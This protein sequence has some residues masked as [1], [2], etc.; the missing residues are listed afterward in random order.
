MD[1]KDCCSK[2]FLTLISTITLGCICAVSIFMIIWIK[3]NQIDQLADSNTITIVVIILACASLLLLIFSVYASCAK[4]RCTSF[5]LAVILLVFDVAL[6]AGA[7]FILAYKDTFYG[8]IGTYWDEEKDKNT[9][10]GHIINKLSDGFKCN[11]WNQ[12]E[13]K[14]LPTC[15]SVVDKYIVWVAVGFIVLAVI[16]FAG[17]FVAFRNVC[18]KDDDED[19][20]KKDQVEQPLSYGW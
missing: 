19:E 13:K 9:T 18:K 17:V 4:N 11:G 2:F 7:V 12:S 20:K 16:L 1:C 3:T 15:R 6:A 8:F 5:I 10:I 14:D